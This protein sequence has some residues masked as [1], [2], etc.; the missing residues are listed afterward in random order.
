[1]FIAVDGK[2]KKYARQLADLSVI[3]DKMTTSV[4]KAKKPLQDMITEAKA[5]KV[6]D[7]DKTGNKATNL[8][9]SKVM[10]EESK[11]AVKKGKETKKT[12]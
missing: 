12:K 5:K 1:M 3:A 2:R 4:D 6:V 11:A 7:N 8:K 9:I 10:A